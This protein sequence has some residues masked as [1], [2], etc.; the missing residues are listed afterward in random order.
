MKLI[1]LSLVSLFALAGIARADVTGDYVEARSASVFT[2][3]CHFNGELVTTGRE[4]I[5]AWSIKSGSFDEVD[6]TGIRA[7]AIVSSSENLS[8]Q[9]ATRRAEVIVDDAASQEQ[10]KAVVAMLKAKSSD[11]L[12]S[13]VSVRRAPVRFDQR[14]GRFTVAAGKIAKLDI[15]AMPDDACCKQPND[16]WYT[17]LT[18]LTSQKV[19]YTATARYVGGAAGDGWERGDENSAFYGQFTL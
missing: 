1:A 15:R 12:G 4:A 2:G 8:D 9:S 14:D 6:L 19:G 10:L 17:P 11:T 13:I 16:V 5:V 3:A 7:M 18:K